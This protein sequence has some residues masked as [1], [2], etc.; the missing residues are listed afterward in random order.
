MLQIEE[1][2]HEMQSSPRRILDVCTGS[3]VQALATLAML[4]LLNNFDAQPDLAVAVDVN[5]RALRFTSFNARLNG[6]DD[7]IITI[8]GDLLSGKAYPKSSTSDDICLVEEILSKL[9]QDETTKKSFQHKHG[10]EQQPKFDI[11]LANPPFI[12]VP[13]ERSDHAAFSLRDENSNC[14]TPN[15]PRYGLFSSGG[16]S[17]EDCLRAIVQMGPSL[18][19][20]DGGLMVV[21][22]EFM[23]PPPLSSTYQKAA[24][25]DDSLTT[26]MGE[27]WGSQL[28]SS[29]DGTGILFTNEFAIRSD[30][31]AQRR[32]VTN[33]QEDMNVWSNHLHRSGIHSV[34][35]GLL[36]IQTSNSR[37]EPRGKGLQLKHYFVPK[38]KYGSI[39]TP[40]NFVAVE[41]TQGVLLDLFR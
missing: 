13:P 21:V 31:Y 7:K 28:T 41:F 29:S 3:G 36:F 2:Q 12:P 10:H 5:K 18:L 40:H 32:A 35:P 6:I 25:E 11:F 16:A 14:D 34:S 27:W 39:W 23:N 20:T 17:G 1:R 22:S 24:N 4:Q 26:K 30:I 37:S 9:T 8:S 38:T 33:D 19:R 15:T